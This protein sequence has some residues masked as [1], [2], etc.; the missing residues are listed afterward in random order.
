MTSTFEKTLEPDPTTTLNLDEPLTE[1]IL[2]PSSKTEEFLVDGGIT[3][4]KTLTMTD[5]SPTPSLETI[6]TSFTV[7]QK[8]LRTHVLPV[9]AYGNLTTEYT[10]LQTYDI[11]SLITATKTISPLQV[12]Q[13]EPSKSFKD[14][15]SILDEAG[16]EVNL[17][18]EFGDE[19]NF[20][21]IEHDYQNKNSNDDNSDSFSAS[22]IAQNN[23]N[24]LA[25]VIDSLHSP[26]NP[27]ATVI[28]TT[29]P[30]V[31]KETIWESHVVPITKGSSI[32]YRTLSKSVGVI[33]KTEYVIN[34]STLSLPQ[35]PMQPSVSINPF[36]LPIP[37]Q[38]Q[39]LTSS[40]VHQ[41]I[42]TQVNSKVLKLTFGAR[43]AY[44]TIFS[45]EVK[46]TVVTEIITT[47]FPIQPTAAFPGYYP[48]P[49]HPYPYIG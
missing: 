14:F 2:A 35:L 17:E 42:A 44:T 32:S 38:F 49:Y 24:S 12:S 41:T 23:K 40:L 27:F 21:N 22:L 15:D 11:T 3:T 18:L 7:S 30:V 1:N 8:V 46:P 34:T 5:N 48:P 47:A 6:T 39:T 43:T 29:V 4:L 20:E 37:P 33:D 9:I 28:T 10:F 25:T 36:L 19:D 13:F 26:P 31:K 16:S 45:T